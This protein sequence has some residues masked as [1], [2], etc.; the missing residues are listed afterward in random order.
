VVLRPDG[1]LRPI[2]LELM[3]GGIAGRD[4]VADL[5]GSNCAIGET[6]GEANKIRHP[7]SRVGRD[8]LG[9]D[10]V[11][12]LAS[13]PAQDVRLVNRV[14]QSHPLAEMSRG[15]PGPPLVLPQETGRSDCAVVQRRADL[16][17]SRGE[18]P[19]MSN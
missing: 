7:R 12:L 2:Q 13:E 18:A 1:T 10:A 15:G 5:A 8:L 11:S 17:I 16:E 14:S 4:A 19:R 6:H 9:V 3:I